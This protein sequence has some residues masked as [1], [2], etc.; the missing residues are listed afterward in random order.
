MDVS[1]LQQWLSQNLL[2][3]IIIGIGLVLLYIYSGPIVNR[4]VRRTLRATEGD[5]E[6][7]GVHE[8]ELEKRSATI[9]GLAT[10]LIRLAIISIGVFVFIGLTGGGW[11]LIVMGVFVAGIA[12]AGQSIVLDYLMGVLILLE[13]QFFQGDDIE[14]GQLPWKGTVE[15]VGLRRTVIRSVDGTVYSV[16]NGEL[17]NVANRTRVY[18]AAEVQV[19]GIR[20]GD[21]RKVVASMD[22][23]GREVASDPGFS[24][25]VLAAPAVTF[26]DDADEL[27]STAKMRGKVVASERWRIATEIRMRLDEALSAE[28]IELNR[29]ALPGG[30]LRRR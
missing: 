20:Q 5:F 9:E 15:S 14:L 28:G 6:V 27:G 3:L 8:A 2:T 16:S 12:I 18:A 22:R 25:A 30:F 4:L 7:T 24:A 26:V 10:T 21:L 11:V 1:G 23:V 13:G 29:Q 17:R 19:R